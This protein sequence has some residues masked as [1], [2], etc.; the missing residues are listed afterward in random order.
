ML[1]IGSDPAADRYDANQWGPDW[2]ETIA[3]KGTVCEKREDGFALL[4][5]FSAGVEEQTRKLP[6]ADEV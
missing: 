5:P 3:H 2:I 1:M 4:L 6:N